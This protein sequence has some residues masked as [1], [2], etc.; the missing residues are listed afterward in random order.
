M[1]R[2]IATLALVA[3]IGAG[4]GGCQ[5]VQ[6]ALGWHV[7]ARTSAMATVGLTLLVKGADDYTAC[8]Q[9]ARLPCPAG[10]PKSD[11]TISVS[12]H[13]KITAAYAAQK[14]LRE[15]DGTLDAVWAAIDAA[16]AYATDHHITI[17]ENPQ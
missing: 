16:K 8:G 10:A 5:T 13:E 17:P 11:L 12:L 15:G 4:S 7:G 1:K 14:R 9:P 2:V 6:D 3:I